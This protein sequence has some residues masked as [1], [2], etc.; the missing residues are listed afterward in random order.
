ML[1]TVKRSVKISLVILMIIISI[2]GVIYLTVGMFHPGNVQGDTIWVDMDRFIQTKYIRNDV[3]FYFIVSDVDN[4]TTETVKVT[5]GAYYS[6]HV[7][8]W[9]DTTKIQTTEIIEGDEYIRGIVLTLIM[10]MTVILLCLLIIW[11]VIVT[12]MR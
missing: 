2:L 8:D 4:F 1:E 6:Y 10:I 9:Y 5:E 12:R 11:V 7:D 3:E